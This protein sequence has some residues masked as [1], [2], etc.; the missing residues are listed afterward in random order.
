MAL[1][2]WYPLNGNLSDYSDERN[3]LVNNSATPDNSGKIGQCY[4]FEK[5]SK[6]TPLDQNVSQEDFKTYT[7]AFWVMLTMR[8]DTYGYILHRS[9]DHSVGNAVY[10][11][12]FTG[13]RKFSF[14]ANGNHVAGGTNV[15]PEL[16]KWYHLAMTDDNGSVKG[17]ID[18]ELVKTF[19][20]TGKK[21]VSGTSLGIGGAVK[22]YGQRHH[23]GRLNDVR[24]YNHILTQTEIKDLVKAKVLHYTFDTK[25][26]TT[27]NEYRTP[28]FN[29]AAAAGG[30]SHW[31]QA[32]HK[33]SYG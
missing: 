7:I 1:V 4:Y 26:Q 10:S 16:N 32:G 13:D 23:T 11:I 17:Y 19:S 3:H 21:N 20:Y 24:R 31:G 2:A 22:P 25:D 6:L 27:R 29:T 12:G 9:I 5:G 15:V 8:P 14:A 18:G 33:G 28:D 30:F